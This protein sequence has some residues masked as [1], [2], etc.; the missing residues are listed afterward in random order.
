[1]SV[2]VNVISTIG[3]AYCN[4]NRLAKLSGDAQISTCSLLGIKITVIIPNNFDFRFVVCF[5]SKCTWHNNHN[6]EHKS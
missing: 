3:I 6:H 1:M 5:K 4:I 2:F